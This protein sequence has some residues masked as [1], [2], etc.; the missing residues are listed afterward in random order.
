MSEDFG[1]EKTLFLVNLREME[2]VSFDQVF[3]KVFR[4]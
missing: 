4:V 3:L 1:C 2:L